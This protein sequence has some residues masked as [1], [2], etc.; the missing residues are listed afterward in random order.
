MGKRGI[1]FLPDSKTRKK[2]I[3]LSS[4]AL[5]VLANV[6]RIELNAYIIAGAKVGR[7]R[8]DLKKP[9]SAIRKAADLE[10]IRLHDLRHTFASIGAGVSLGLPIIGKL[11]GHSQ[12]STTARYAHLDADP[13]RR[14]ATQIGNTISAVMDK[15]T[16]DNVVNLKR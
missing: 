7:S 16:T 9:W 3:Y 11:L 13:M 10:D 14:A 12:P 8:V 5:S 2:P 4:A 15:N 1:L 6:P